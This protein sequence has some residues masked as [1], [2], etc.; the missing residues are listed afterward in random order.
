MRV[1]VFKYYSRVLAG[2]GQF[3]GLVLYNFRIEV[4]DL[5]AIAFALHFVPVHFNVCSAISLVQSTA[6]QFPASV[7]EGNLSG[8]PRE[9]PDCRVGSQTIWGLQEDCPG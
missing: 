8:T 7:D 2:H 4:H 5:I 6:V 9:A 3:M 1:R